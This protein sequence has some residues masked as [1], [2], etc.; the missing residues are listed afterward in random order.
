MKGRVQDDPARWRAPTRPCMI[1]GETGT[2]KELDRRGAPPQLDPR[3]RSPFVKMNCAALHENLLESELFGHER[4]AYTGADRQRIGR[5]EL[6]NEGHALPRR[7]RQH[8]RSRPRPRCC[9]SCRSA[10]SSASAARG[11]SRS[12]SAWWR[13]PTSNL[14]EAIASQG[15]F[16]RGSLLQAQRRHDLTVPPLRERKEDIVPLAKLLHRPGFGSEM[17]Q[18]RP[19]HRARRRCALLQRHTWPGNIRELENAIERAVLMCESEPYDRPVE[20]LHLT[21]QQRR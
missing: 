4:G 5:F 13:R 8:E 21:A 16:P 14:E 9:A 18:A 2:G 6:A 12:T 17:K 7:D 1:L 19:R 15:E 3:R 11:R 20:D 10:S